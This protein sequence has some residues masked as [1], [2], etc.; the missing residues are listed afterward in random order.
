[1]TEPQVGV[2]Q[3]PDESASHVASIRTSPAPPADA[4]GRAA[5]S[6]APPQPNPTVSRA[7]RERCPRLP[8]RRGRSR[9]R[10]IRP[11]P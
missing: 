4:S 3:Q 5:P 7:R 2:R 8:A 11:A 10:S 1:M 9:S 6:S